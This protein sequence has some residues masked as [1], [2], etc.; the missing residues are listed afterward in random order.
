MIISNL[1]SRR[2]LVALA[3]FAIVALSAFGFA[4]ANTVPGSNAG[5]GSGTISGY[6]VSAIHYTL[7]SSSPANFTAVSF[8]LSAAAGSARAGINAGA[9]V[10]C[11]NTSG[12]D[13]NCVMGGAVASAA[14]LRV[15]AAD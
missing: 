3:V 14:S 6:T 13:W 4:A 12:N 8:T 5:D 1:K 15:V 11:A 7:D 2:R 10:A 9:T